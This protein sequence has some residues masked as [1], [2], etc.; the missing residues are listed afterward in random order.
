[1]WNEKVCF[2]Y[3][4][5]CIYFIPVGQSGFFFIK[6]DLST[7][8]IVGHQCYTY[9]ADQTPIFLHKRKMM[10]V[11]LG[12]GISFVFLRIC[13]NGI[14]RLCLLGAFLCI[15]RDNDLHLLLFMPYRL[16]NGAEL[17]YYVKGQVFDIFPC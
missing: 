6:F 11:A 14:Y 13:I 15:G 16:P 1:M 9:C 5:L 4:S 12:E 2:L 10:M 7:I 17:A 3:F 8:C